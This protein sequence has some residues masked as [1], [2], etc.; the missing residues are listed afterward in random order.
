MQY[1][2]YLSKPG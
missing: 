1:E 2:L